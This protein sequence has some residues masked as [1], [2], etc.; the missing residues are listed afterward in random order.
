MKSTT[1]TRRL[2]AATLFGAMA[3][4]AVSA[5]HAQTNLNTAI[6]ALNY[7]NGYPTKEMPTTS[8]VAS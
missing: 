4:A 6:G 5:A 1:R 7:E 8:S 3:V 2:V